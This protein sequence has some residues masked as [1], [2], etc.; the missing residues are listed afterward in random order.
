MTSIRSKQ[1]RAQGIRMD[2]DLTR[3]QQQERADL[4]AD[5]AEL[6]EN[7]VTSFFQRS[8]VCIYNGRKKQFCRKGQAY[9]YIA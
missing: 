9:K 3:M 8:S 1:L 4:A 7:G 6:K 5:F 2:D